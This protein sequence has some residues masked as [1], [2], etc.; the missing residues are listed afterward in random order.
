MSTDTISLPTDSVAAET[1]EVSSE[2]SAIKFGKYNNIPPCPKRKSA[3]DG[4]WWTSTGAEEGSITYCEFCMVNG[5]F[6]VSETQSFQ[7]PYGMDCNCDCPCVLKQ[8]ILSHDGM[9]VSIQSYEESGTL[10][11]L[12]D[13]SSSSEY[14]NF[15]KAIVPTASRYQ[16]EIFPIQKSTMFWYAITSAKIGNENVTINGDLPIYNYANVCLYEYS[17]MQ[18]KNFFFI[19]PSKKEIE[20]GV[21]HED[22][23]TRDHIEIKIQ[24]Y[25]RIPYVEGSD[26]NKQPRSKNYVQG[27]RPEMTYDTFEKIGDES[28]FQ[29]QLVSDQSEEDK[30]RINREYHQKLRVAKKRGIVRRIDLWKQLQTDSL[31]VIES[32]Q[33]KCQEYSES[34]AKENEELKNYSDIPDATV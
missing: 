19:S 17:T 33:K 27:L 16:I 15:A 10:P 28:T 9:N 3:H 14:S 31:Q 21:K 25:H 1:K 30:Y 7:P 20:E 13:T 23:H 22:T 6:D 11:L 2:S 18:R 32:H 5:H 34:I 29:I 4:R 12:K 24:K 8:D 26:T